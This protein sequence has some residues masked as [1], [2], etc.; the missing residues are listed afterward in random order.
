VCHC[1]RVTEAVIIEALSTRQITTVKELRS[2]TGAGEG[3]MAC[4]R[5][6]KRYIELHVCCQTN[7]VLETESVGVIVRTS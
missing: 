7:A 4:V 1:L 3:C 6:L 5:K 2:C